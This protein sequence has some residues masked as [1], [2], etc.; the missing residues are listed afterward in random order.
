MN[1]LEILG[2]LTKDVETRYTPNG[3]IIASFNVAVKRKMSKENE[4]DFFNLT[5]FGKTAEF[6]EKYFHKGQWIALIG[7]L[8][9]NNY[10]D[11]D[12]KK[13][14]TNEI[15]VEE[16]Y[17]CGP[18]TK[19]EEPEEQFIPNFNAINDDELPF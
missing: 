16:V 18:S 7:R 2:R 13:H 6:I 3:K 15:I 8:Q 11:K 12:G 10:E 17:F 19:Q 4:S 1:K 14:Y 5:A 9:N